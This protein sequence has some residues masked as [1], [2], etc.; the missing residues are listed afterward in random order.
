MGL[1][2]FVK[3]NLVLLAG[4]ALPVVMMAGFLIASSL[5]QAL[6]NPPG[7][8]LVF[9]TDDYNSGNSNNLPVTVNLV[10]RN[11]TLVAQYV[12]VAGNA[13]YG[14]WKKIYRYEAATRTVRE[15]PF[16]FPADLST[17]TALREEPV[18]GLENAR[19]D[20]RLQAPDGYELS[21]DEYRGNGLIGD[22]FWRNGTG[23]PR[24]RNGASSVPLELASDTQ[25]YTYGN[26]QFLG[27]V[28]P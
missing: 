2:K 28:V 17:I 25:Y 3:E 14:Y 27:W 8:D 12:P 4:I 16:G 24:L 23:R 20:T 13:T 18:A 21:T 26:I 9:F 6:A 7:Y 10:V 15:I 11:G 22:L 5:P 1:G 19:L